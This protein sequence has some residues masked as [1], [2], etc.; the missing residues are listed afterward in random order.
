MKNHRFF[1]ICRRVILIPKM[2]MKIK[3]TSR[4]IPEESAEKIQKTTTKIMFRNFHLKEHDQGIY[5][6]E[7]KY[8]VPSCSPVTA[9][10]SKRNNVPHMTLKRLICQRN[11]HCWCCSR[12][13]WESASSDSYDSSVTDDSLSIH[14]SF[15]SD[16]DSDLEMPKTR[17]R[18][19][20]RRRRV[21][22][23][24]YTCKNI[25]YA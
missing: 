8:S 7:H 1:P 2:V 23:Y 4:S 17:S 22:I 19:K 3:T 24:I 18:K 10:Q 9:C 12:R 11:Q 5:L 15:D 20:Q 6:I 25:M 14:T 13:R 16:S 21:Y